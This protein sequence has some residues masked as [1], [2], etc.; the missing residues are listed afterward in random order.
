MVFVPP[1]VVGVDFGVGAQIPSVARAL[2]RH[3]LLE[4]AGSGF[5]K[6]FGCFLDR[7]FTSSVVLVYVYMDMWGGSPRG[8]ILGFG[9]IGPLL[10]G[11]A[12]SL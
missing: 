8:I 2:E 4:I 9:G 10:T 11:S 3:F 6:I 1:S 5:L 12:A 7:M